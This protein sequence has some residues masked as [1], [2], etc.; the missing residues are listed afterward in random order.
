MVDRFRSYVTRQRDFEPRVHT[1]LQK[2]SRERLANI[3]EIHGSFSE[4]AFKEL[5]DE[6][7]T[8]EVK[9]VSSNLDHFDFIMHAD[10]ELVLSY[11]E[12]YIRF[13]LSRVKRRRWVPPPTEGGVEKAILKIYD[14]L[15]TEGLLFEIDTGSG[16]QFR[17]MESEAMDE[18]DR[19]IQALA[20]EEPWKDALQGY[21]DAFQRWKDG[22]YDELI[23][24]KL[25]NSIEEILKVICVDLEGWTDDR[26]QS[27]KFYLD[28]LNEKGVYAAHGVTAPELKDLLNSMERMVS[29]VSD[30]RKQRH[31][32]HDRTYS[33]LL[34]H[35]VGAYIYF[36]ISRYESFKDS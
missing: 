34:I 19:E 32:Y 25:Y 16:F 6:V 22:D 5:M 18:A 4:R 36:L 17:P 1:T 14:V 23:P 31:A 30:D 11:L 26:K 20:E 15:V 10:T 29:K 2:R 27:H 13:A 21:N 28:S 33:T 8:S 35:Q 9:D 12:H 24:K 7:G 3:T